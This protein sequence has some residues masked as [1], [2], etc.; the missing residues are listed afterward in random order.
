M[1]E[2]ERMKRRESEEE[3]QEDCWR[4]HKRLAVAGVWIEQDSSSS[5]E[6]D[7]PCMQ[8][9][10]ACNLDAESWGDICEP[11][12]STVS[13]AVRKVFFDENT[14]EALDPKAVAAGEDEEMQRFERMGVYICVRRREAMRLAQQGVAKIVG[15][16]WVRTRKGAGA[17]RRLVAQ[18]LAMGTK[19]K[20]LFA[21]TPQLYV[22]KFLL[23]VAA[24]RRRCTVMILD[25]KTAFF[26]GFIKST[27]FI[28]LPEQGPRSRSGRFVGSLVKA[29][30]GTRDAPQIWR[31]EVKRFM[32]SRVF[33]SSR[34]HP[35][36]FSHDER[37]VIVATHV[38]DFLCLG[39]Q[40]QQEWLVKEMRKEYEVKYS[41]L[42]EG[43]EEE[44]CYLNR[45]LKWRTDG[46]IWFADPK[47]ARILQEELG[48]AHC[49]PADIAFGS[50]LPKLGEPG[51][52]EVEGKKASL[53]RRCVARENYLAQD[54]VDLQVVSKQLSQ[55]MASPNEG[56]EKA[57]KRVARYLQGKEGMGQLSPWGADTGAVAVQGSSD[58]DWAGDKTRRRSTSGGLL[59][60]E[61]A[62]L[63]SWSKAQSNIAL[64]SAE[65]EL[66]A[67]VKLISEA[68]GLLELC[69][70]LGVQVD[71]SSISI[72]AAACKGIL[73]RQGC[74][75]I[76]RLSLKQL[77]VQEAVKRFAFDVN[78]I[79]RACNLSD[80]L[81][82]ITNSQQFTNFLLTIL[83]CN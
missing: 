70:E 39:A 75:R 16:R 78:Q 18:E 44:A 20:E 1:S 24:A 32:V 2:Q 36:F 45:K 51:D 23:C 82:H 72:D 41:L 52:K 15:A 54:R 42:G 63:S 62:V 8:E 53:L 25:V 57:V 43:L 71:S 83:L 11:E 29:M 26:F 73:L 56:C 12:D 67:A 81:I 33:R 27:V 17:K 21:G 48:M 77:W 7:E 49:K 9:D 34:L 38:D 13:E 30:Y 46:L 19:E 74:G 68:I 37:G 31:E 6:G 22:F 61:G 28:K 80:N 58:S 76:R 5:E 59:L 64:S 40:D 35:G 4:E 3:M 10:F 14:W 66:K 50:E 69:Q 65:A 47:H 79:E 60:M 55:H